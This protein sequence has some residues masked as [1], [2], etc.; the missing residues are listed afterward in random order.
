M[1]STVET[2]INYRNCPYSLNGENLANLRRAQL[3]P[4]AAAVGI[5]GEFTKN[6][7]LT[8]LIEKLSAMG[9][10]SDIAEHWKQEQEA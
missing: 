3:Q 7:L 5:R 8:R 6:Q 1:K 4:I 10:S 2:I 9:A